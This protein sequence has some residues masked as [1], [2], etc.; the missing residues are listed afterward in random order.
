MSSLFAVITITFENE[1]L[2]ETVPMSWLHETTSEEYI[3]YYPRSEHL[4]EI[5]LRDPSR[6]KITSNWLS[7]KCFVLEKDTSKYFSTHCI[8]H[9]FYNKDT[10]ICR[11]N[12]CKIF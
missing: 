4:F 11:M 2:Y 5:G 6:L 9:F 7:T 12:K 8:L 3:V 10:I 1:R